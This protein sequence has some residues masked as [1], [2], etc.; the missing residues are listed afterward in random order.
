MFMFRNNFVLCGITGWGFECFFTGC[1][2]FFKKDKK[3]TCKT[4]LW[5]FGIYGMG[6]LIKPIYNMIKN[7]PTFFR[8]IIYSII[9]FLTEFITGFILKKHKACPWDYS[10]SKY[11]IKG[12]IRLDYAP[13][14]FIVGL[15][16]EK[17]LTSQHSTKQ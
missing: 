7:I 1:K 16:Y 14:W 12:F 10:D 11:N 8:G 2:G 3:L 5:M 13:L 15:I 6:F 9:I 17:I 4:S